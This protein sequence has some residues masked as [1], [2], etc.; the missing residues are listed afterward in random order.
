MQKVALFA[1]Q[2]FKLKKKK[3]NDFYFRIHRMNDSNFP[4]QLTNWHHLH[5]V[6]LTIYQPYCLFQLSPNGLHRDSEWLQT[7]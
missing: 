2:A 7:A 6:D 4:L 1:P 5:I 3:T